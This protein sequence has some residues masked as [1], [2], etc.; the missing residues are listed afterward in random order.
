MSVKRR[1]LSALGNIGRM[2]GSFGRRVAGN[3]PKDYHQPSTPATFGRDTRPPLPSGDLTYPV[4]DPVSNTWVMPDE[5]DALYGR[6][7]SSNPRA[8]D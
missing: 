5:Q 4:Y 2:F 8:S 1:A 7:A 3:P 6:I